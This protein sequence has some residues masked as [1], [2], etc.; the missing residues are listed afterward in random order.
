MQY[1]EEDEEKK[2]VHVGISQGES[3]S[4]HLSRWSASSGSPEV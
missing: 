1:E 2:W 4:G 3:K